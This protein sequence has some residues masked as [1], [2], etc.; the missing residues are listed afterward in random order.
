MIIAESKMDEKIFEKLK[1]IYE[2]DFDLKSNNVSTQSRGFLV[3]S[4]KT[5]IQIDK[6]KIKNKHLIAFKTKIINEDYALWISAVLFPAT[7]DIVEVQ[8]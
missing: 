3:I 2:Y 6:F 1:R 8:I 5:R 4:N 7:N